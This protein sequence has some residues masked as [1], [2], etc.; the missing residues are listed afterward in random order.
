[1]MFM[2]TT[3]CTPSNTLSQSSYPN[4]RMFLIILLPNIFMT[5]QQVVLK[6]DVYVEYTTTCTPSNTL[7]QSRYPNNRI[8]LIILLPNILLTSLL[9]PTNNPQAASR[10]G[11]VY[12]FALE[13][14]CLSP[15]GTCP[16]RYHAFLWIESCWIANNAAAYGGAVYSAQTVRQ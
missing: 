6:Y 3:A 14:F 11:A 16:H 5:D 2:Y 12:A 15:P 13:P 1:M 4:N 9:H 8:L 7:S 10:G